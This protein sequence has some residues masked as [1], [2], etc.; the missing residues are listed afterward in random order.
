[1]SPESEAA[2]KLV[3][4]AQRAAGIA[5][6][7][8]DLARSN[9]DAIV[10]LN[11]RDRSKGRRIVFMAVAVAMDVV[12]SGVLTLAL[13]QV[14][15]LTDRLDTSQTVTRRNS[16]CPLYTLLKSTETPAARAAAPDKAAYDHAVMVIRDGYTALGC[17]E[18]VTSPPTIGS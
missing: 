12:L 14:H 7:Y 9:G 1:V 18:F 8:A 15:T 13:I 11:K 16:L 6:E 5:E 10:S 17:A 4:L 2:D 3:E